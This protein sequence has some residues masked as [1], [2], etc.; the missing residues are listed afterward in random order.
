MRTAK[1]LAVLALPILS[2]ALLAQDKPADAPPPVTLTPAE[3]EFQTS[4]ASVYLEGVFT[5]GPTTELHKDRYTIDSVTKV[6]DELWKVAA[7]IQY[8]G[9]DV[10]FAMN[11]PVKWAGDTPMISLTNF[12][13]PMLGTFS[14]RILFY[15]GEYAGTWSGT[16]PNHGGI[17]FGKIR[18]QDAAT[19]ESEKK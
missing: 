9:K 12:G 5:N 1:I 11:V 10:K 7:R 19:T 4:M 17:L 8:N 14:A 18:K 6:K 3:A 13:V 15:K 16:G 2:V